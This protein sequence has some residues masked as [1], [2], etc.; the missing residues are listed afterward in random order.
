MFDQWSN[1]HSLDLTKEVRMKVK[2]GMQFVFVKVETGITYGY[3]KPGHYGW[4]ICSTWR[5]G[6]RS[7]RGRKTVWA[8]ELVSVNF[9]DSLVNA[10]RE[11]MLGYRCTQRSSALRIRLV[12]EATTQLHQLHALDQLS[13]PTGEQRAI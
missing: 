5:L 12:V 7:T 1:V 8:E 6:L 10:L 4:K 11:L 2:K 3:I 13:L 9:R